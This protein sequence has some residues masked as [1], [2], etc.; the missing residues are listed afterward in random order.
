MSVQVI[1]AH[2]PMLKLV[3]RKLFE[4]NCRSVPPQFFYCLP[5]ENYLQA[6]IWGREGV[7]AGLAGPMVMIA[8][9][10]VAKQSW[11][12]RRK[13]TAVKRAFRRRLSPQFMILSMC[14]MPGDLRRFVNVPSST[15]CIEDEWWF[16]GLGQKC[17]QSCFLDFV[18]KWIRRIE[19][20][21]R[22]KTSGDTESLAKG[23]LRV[24]TSMGPDMDWPGKLNSAPLP[25]GSKCL[26]RDIRRRWIVCHTASPRVGWV[27]PC[28]SRGTIRVV[29]WEGATWQIW[30]GSYSNERLWCLF[31][32]RSYGES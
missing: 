3:F 14:D 26:V 32:T 1:R 5:L 22:V 18:R 15:S 31:M 30:E 23:I 25:P 2:P 28:V 4:S 21:L 9:H 12:F 10:R 8:A 11:P 13:V 6:Y 16:K 29:G 24:D 19:S 27:T 20:M 7:L 17:C